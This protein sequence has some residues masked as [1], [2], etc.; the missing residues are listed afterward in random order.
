LYGC[1]ECFVLFGALG[2]VNADG[3]GD[4]AVGGTFVGDIKAPTDSSI[5]C[6]VMAK[7]IG[8]VKSLPATYDATCD[9]DLV[10]PTMPDTPAIQAI[11]GK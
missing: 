4:L 10:A 9:C 6:F 8:V 3:F 11:Y 5:S 2:D 1:T 7:C